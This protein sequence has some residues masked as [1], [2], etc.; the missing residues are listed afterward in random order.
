MHLIFQA[1]GCKFMSFREERASASVIGLDYVEGW[2]RVKSN[3]VK[4][5][6]GFEIGPGG[7]NEFFWDCDGL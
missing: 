3:D 1:A 2:G 6:R 4:K 7:K 5:R